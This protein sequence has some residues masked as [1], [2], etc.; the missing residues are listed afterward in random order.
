VTDARSDNSKRLLSAE[1]PRALGAYYTPAAAAGWMADWVAAEGC[2]S[3]LEPSMGDGAFVQAVRERGLEA[4]AVELAADTFAAAAASGAVEPGHA[5]FGDFLALEPFP[6]DAVIGNPPYVRLRHLPKAEARRAAAAAEAALGGRIDP[7]ASVWM[8][9]VLHASRFLRRGGSMALV[10]PYE[11]TYVRYARPLWRFLGGAFSELRVVRVH[12]RLF[13]AILQDVVLLL[14]SGFGGSAEAA[15]LAV[16][17]RV[18]DL[19]AGRPERVATVPLAAVVAGERPFV[20]ALLPP[21]L[22]GLLAGRVREATV[23]ARELVQFRIG[24]VSGDKG[25]FHPDAE[26]VGRFGLQ[27]AHLVSALPSGRELR[28]CGIR[29][30]G[31]SPPAASRLYLPDPAALEPGER[32]YIARGEAA[33]VSAR[34]KCRVRDPWFLT[35]GVRIPNVVVPVF[36]EAPVLLSNDAGY[37]ASNSLLCGYLRPGTTPPS[38]LA[39]WYTSLT[40]LQIELEVHALGGGVRVF[41]PNEA[42]AI[43]LPPRAR[44]SP[45]RL[46]RIDGL[47]RGG[48]VQR[49]YEDGDEPVLRR[50]LGLRPAE[51]ELIRE[52]VAQLERWRNSSR[53][54]R[55]AAAA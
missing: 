24:Y 45:R 51:I 52:G 5:L 19:L 37:V 32:A 9:F 18:R 34:Y 28:G 44:A 41:V 13:P 48:R 20:E 31:L 23:P 15:E 54:S 25:F 30:S 35:P 50:Q 7:S 46:D 17:E 49:A 8:P 43:R 3:V 33:G 55:L 21:E 10:L 27:S 42:G 26:T 47:V 38:L 4:W 1:T 22:R 53:T 12:E 16:Y 14:A 39:G 29:T 11:A 40:L 6:V 36:A 2:R